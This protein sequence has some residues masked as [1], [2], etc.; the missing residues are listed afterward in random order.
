VSAKIT[1][2]RRA[3][4]LKALAQSGNI[5]VSAERSGV[6][7]GWVLEA[8][9]CDPEFDAACAAAIE[10]CAEALARHGAMKPPKGWGHLDG[11]ALVV[12]G[13]GGSGGGKRVQ[14]ARAR[15]GQITAGVEDR[16]L[17]AL[18]DTCN[19]QA[20][21]RE[22][23]V[24]KGAIYTHRKRWPAFERRWQAA[25]EEGWVRLDFLLL[26]CASNPMSTLEQKARASQALHSAHMHKYQVAR[27][28][29]RP[30]GW[31]RPPSIEDVAAK[32][33]RK[34]EQMK[35]ADS[36]SEEKKARDQR[37]WARRREAGEAAPARRGQAR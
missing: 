23:G 8:R 34:A 7:R 25:L 18:E 16:F 29:R 1:A 19:V 9:K 31:A 35:R 3:A 4:F 10:A 22:A 13:T 27:I 20:A 33:I 30:G 5:T 36:I 26:E 24:S 14:V 21:Y 6:S 28:G 17:A 37:V 11:M 15:A 2:T 32:I 12:R